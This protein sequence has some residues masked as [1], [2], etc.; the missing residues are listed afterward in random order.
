MQESHQRAASLGRQAHQPI[1]EGGLKAEAA[2]LAARILRLS[3]LGDM[4]SVLIIG[5]VDNIRPEARDV[6]LK[7]L[8]EY[9]E[10][11]TLPILWAHD[12]GDVAGTVL[13]RCEVVWCPDGPLAETSVLH[14]AEKML[15]AWEA[16][17]ISTIIE[18]VREN[19]EDRELLLSAG[20]L[21]LAK[22]GGKPHRLWESIRR[23]MELKNPTLVEVLVAWLP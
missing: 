12:A 20:A 10:G 15:S 21:L 5:P 19:K 6:L 4:E 13:S 16:G 22:R 14:V 1:G 11:R 17:E 9:Q 8:E 3:P 7:P 2:R 18:A 23:A